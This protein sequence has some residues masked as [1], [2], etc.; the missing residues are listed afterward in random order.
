MNERLAELIGGR[1]CFTGDQVFEQ[2]AKWRAHVM[3]QGGLH[4]AVIDGLPMGTS[5]GRGR[6][7]LRWI[8]NMTKWS[9]RSVRELRKAATIREQLMAATLGI[10]PHYNLRMKWPRT[11]VYTE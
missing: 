2:K 10:R 11:Q 8:D 4:N 6:P 3:R 1:W 5:R 7:K 9:G